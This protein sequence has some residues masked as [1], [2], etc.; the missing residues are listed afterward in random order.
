MIFFG[1]CTESLH[2]E[3]A[4]GD[5]TWSGDRVIWKTKISPRRRGE[6]KNLYHG[7]TLMALI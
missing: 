3:G 2:G 6:I 5:C 1:S 4:Q 7:L